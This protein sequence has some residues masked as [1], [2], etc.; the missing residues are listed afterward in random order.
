MKHE[1][2][3]QTPVSVPII[4][5][6]LSNL[7][8]VDCLSPSFTKANAEYLPDERDKKTVYEYPDVIEIKRGQT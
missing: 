5:T 4:K 1:V 7:V 6:L 3:K 8:T 2:C